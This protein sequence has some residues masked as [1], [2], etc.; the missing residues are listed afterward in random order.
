MEIDNRLFS[1]VEA[2]PPNP[3]EPEQ[4]LREDEME[5]FHGVWVIETT[6]DFSSRRLFKSDMS[7]FGT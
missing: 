6:S 3:D 5:G 2:S 7:I 4:G 1:D